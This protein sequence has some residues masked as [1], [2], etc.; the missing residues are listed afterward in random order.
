MTMEALYDQG[1]RDWLLEHLDKQ[2]DSAQMEGRAMFRYLILD[3]NEWTTD[4]DMFTPS[5]LTKLRNL[6]RNTRMRLK[7]YHPD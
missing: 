1:V 7:R 4:N 5:M 3:P 2:H 6:L